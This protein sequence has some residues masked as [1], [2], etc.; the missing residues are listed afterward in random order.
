MLEDKIEIWYQK[1]GKKIVIAL[2][3]IAAIYLF[4]KLKILSLIAPFIIAWILA[5]IL[6]PFVTWANR[7]A[8]I[9]RGIAT[10]I[11][12]LTIMSAVL[13][14][15]TMIIKQ[16]WY[17]ISGFIGDIPIYTKD[18]I[19]QLNIMEEQLADV[20]G[21]LPGSQAIT[22]LDSVVQQFFNSITNIFTPAIETV[23]GTIAKVPDMVVFIII[24][25]LSTFFMTKDYYIIKAFIKAQFS[26]TAINR[27]VVMQKGILQAI[28]G[29][30]RTQLI[31]MS[32]TFTICLTG[33]F[34]FKIEYA[35]VLSVIIAIVDALPVFGSG[36]ILLPWTLYHFV[37]GNYSMA[38]G[39]LSIYGVIF[40]MRQIMEPK[41][42]STQI[43]V[44]ALATI[45]AVYTGYKTIGV[46]GLIV[47]PAVVVTLKMLQ[48]VGVLPPFKPV[49]KKDTRG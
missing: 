34:I 13:S 43:G 15:I 30:I 10:I 3:I 12:M 5:S 29:Y 47:G 35:L 44:Y 21:I 48:N 19:N 37:G 9:H 20:I 8:K 32:I 16:L 17:Q 4:V 49:T 31:L 7:R 38:I 23:S 24:M 27:A 36:T 41:I 18:I 14:L 45:I 22:N 39:L 6:N 42:L 11:S 33:L 40:V 25:L 46:L 1:V 2:C 26:D 28:G